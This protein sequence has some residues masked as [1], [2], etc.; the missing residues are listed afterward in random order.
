[1]K[2]LFQWLYV[3]IEPTTIHFVAHQDMEKICDRYM[4]FHALPNVLMSKN[5]IYTNDHAAMEKHPDPLVRYKFFTRHFARH[6][7]RI[8]QKEIAIFLDMSEKML[9]ALNKNKGLRHINLHSST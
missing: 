2:P 1:M 8:P 5:L 4:R 9:E 6:A 3:A 7:P